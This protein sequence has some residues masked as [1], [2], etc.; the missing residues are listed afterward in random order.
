LLGRDRALVAGF[1]VMALAFGVVALRP[2]GLAGAVAFVVLLIF[3]QML[4]VPFA[5]E[6]VPMLAGDRRLGAHF[7]VLA[8]AGGVAVLVGSTA[9]GALLGQGRIAWVV[10]GLLPLAGACV[11]A[12]AAR[13]RA[14]T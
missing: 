10:L 5:M 6:L 2:P 12:I 4:V 7:G 11:M 9:S 1:T 14:S 13:R 3:G 8:S